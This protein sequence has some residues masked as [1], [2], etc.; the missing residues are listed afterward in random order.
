[1]IHTAI[2]ATG[3]ALG[4][5]TR[6]LMLFVLG[7]GPLPIGQLAQ[8]AHVTSSSASFHVGKLQRAGLVGVQR[9]GRCSLVRRNERRWAA[10]V[11][12]FALE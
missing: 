2:L 10:I 11:G 1:M 6:L 12:A 5:A 7:G 4:D 8:R 3:A 9:A